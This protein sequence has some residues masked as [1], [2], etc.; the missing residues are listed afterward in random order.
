MATGDVVL[1]QADV[2]LPGILPL[3]IERTH[4]SSHR[5]GQGVLPVAGPAWPLREGADGSWT[6]ADPQRG[7]TWRYEGTPGYWWQPGDGGH[8]QLPLVSITDRAGHQVTFSYNDDGAPRSIT[9]SGDGR[10]QAGNLRFRHDDAGRVASR[11]RTRISRKP[12]TWHYQWDAHDRLT[13][14][15]TP[16]NS[17]WHYSYDA[18][19]RRIAKQHNAPD[20]QPLEHTAFTWDGPVLAEHAGNR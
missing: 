17:T 1:T 2:T 15:T 13:A 16:D 5:A 20:G 8:G 19:G 9:H 12:D 18:L 11:Q 6:V 4:R 14:V 7:L 10:T 3:V